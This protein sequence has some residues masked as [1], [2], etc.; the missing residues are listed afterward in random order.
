MPALYQSTNMYLFV[1]MGL[2][3]F[4]LVVGTFFLVYFGLAT[5]TREA[6]SHLV[7]RNPEDT[8]PLVS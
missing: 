1:V 5:A 6:G 3:A 2:V 4:Q 8:Q 7:Y